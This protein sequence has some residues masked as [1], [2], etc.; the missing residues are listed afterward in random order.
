[1]KYLLNGEPD[2]H[3]LDTVY[4]QENGKYQYYPG[5]EGMYR[6]VCEDTTG[7][8]KSDSTEVQ[9]EPKGGKGWFKGEDIKEVNFD[10]KKKNE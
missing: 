3:Y 6:V 4:T 5:A 8:N 2:P 9:M 7:E 10:L 1:M